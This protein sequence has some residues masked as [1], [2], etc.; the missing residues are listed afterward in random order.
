MRS[1]NSLSGRCALLGVLALT[2]SLVAASARA[3]VTARAL[4]SLPSS[5]EQVSPL[6]NAGTDF[7]ML[8]SFHNANVAN[9]PGGY[10]LGDSKL[11][12]FVVCFNVATGA[13]IPN[14]DV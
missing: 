11:S 14:C 4:A 9:I 5:S 1:R 13:V 6:T 3:Q 2:I 7:T 8:P 10:K 12:L